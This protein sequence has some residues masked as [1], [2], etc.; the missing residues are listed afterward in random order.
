MSNHKATVNELTSHWVLL[1][2]FLGIII[3][4]NIA[5]HIVGS[6]IQIGMDEEQRIILR[7]IFYVISL[8]LFPLANLVRHILLRLN[9]TMPGNNPAKNRYFITIAVTLTMVESV[10]FFGLIMFIFGDKYNTLY[11]F[12]TLAILGI[13]LHRPKK[14]EYLQIIDAINLKQSHN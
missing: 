5:C 1:S 7:T 6:E 9:Q 12:S 8:I 10:G 13:F 14:L 11:I 4:T 2:V 3:I